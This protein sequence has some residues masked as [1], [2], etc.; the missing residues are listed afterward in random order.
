MIAIDLQVRTVS[1]DNSVWRLFPGAG[2]RFLDSF[3]D[4][5]IGYLDFPGLTLPTGK[6]LDK[7]ANLIPLIALSAAYKERLPSEPDAKNIVLREKDFANAK[8]TQSRG[9]LRQALINFYQTAKSGDLVVL[10]EPLYTRDVWIGE[11]VGSTVRYSPY[12]RRPFD[13]TVPSR[14]IRWLS[15]VKENSL[16]PILSEALRHQHPFT[17]VERSRFLE[18]M[19]L[20]YSSFIFKDHHV[21]T[22]YN[23]DDFLNTD[24]SFIGNLAIMHLT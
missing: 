22:I 24:S 16:S 21:A 18:I 11:F 12:Y 7:V 2:Y 23:G 3:M 4:D 14:K 17:L 19:S 9:R 6:P 10:P 5:G 8:H 1:P 15:K 20:A 13:V